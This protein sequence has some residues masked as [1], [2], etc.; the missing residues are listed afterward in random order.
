MQHLPQKKR[1]K[2]ILNFRSMIFML[3]YLRGNVLMTTD[4]GMGGLMDEQGDVEV[5]IYVTRKRSEMLVVESR[6]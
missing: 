4:L 3:N 6:R 5:D 2:Q 1:N